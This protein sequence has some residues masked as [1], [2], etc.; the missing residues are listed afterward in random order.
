MTQTANS[1]KTRNSRS[2]LPLQV[3]LTGNVG[4]LVAAEFKKINEQMEK[5]KEQMDQKFE[6]QNAFFKQVAEN[7]KYPLKPYKVE[8]FEAMFG[9]GVRA[10]QKYRKAGKLGFLKLG[11]TVLYTHKH[12]Q[13]FIQLQDSANKKSKI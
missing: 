3:E 5:M 6:Q 7:T 12:I 4:E 10:Q 1:Y 2:K 8:D 13:E 11:E 9:L